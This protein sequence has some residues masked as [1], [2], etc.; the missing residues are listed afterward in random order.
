[1]SRKDYVA[2]AKA[3]SSEVQSLKVADN[4]D[5]IDTAYTITKVIAD[6]FGA[7]NE[8]FDRDKFITA[9]GFVKQSA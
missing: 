4:W 6:V 8:R 2:I 9:C 7:D 3:I 1:M 5:G